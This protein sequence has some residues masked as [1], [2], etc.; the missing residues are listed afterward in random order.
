MNYT[1]TEKRIK[2]M[3]ENNKDIKDCTN[4]MAKVED[5]D[6]KIYGNNKIVSLERKLTLQFN[7]KKNL[8][9]LGWS[10]LLR[11]GKKSGAQGYSILLYLPEGSNEFVIIR[12]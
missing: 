1:P 3:S 11:L 7:N 5:F 2:I 9:I 10:P 6:L 8:N 4:M 12:K